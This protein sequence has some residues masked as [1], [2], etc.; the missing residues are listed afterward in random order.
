V[1]DS[2][3]SSE[4]AALKGGVPYWKDRRAQLLAEVDSIERNF[5]P[6]EDKPRTCEL[7]RLG[8]LVW[9]KAKGNP[10]LRQELG[11]PEG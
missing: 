10:Y 2:I 11:L 9:K 8:L 3:R 1:A 4:E 5:L 7:R 6:D